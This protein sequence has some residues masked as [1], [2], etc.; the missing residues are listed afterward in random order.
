MDEQLSSEV[1]FSVTNE[2]LLDGQ[3]WEDAGLHGSAASMPRR[4]SSSSRE[5]QKH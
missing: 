3:G 1:V 2:N 4:V 5:N